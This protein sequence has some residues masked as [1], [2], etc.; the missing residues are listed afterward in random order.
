MRIFLCI[1]CSIFFACDWIHRYLFLF[2][3]CLLQCLN[4]FATFGAFLRRSISLSPSI[5][6]SPYITSVLRC[7]DLLYS[8]SFL[9]DVS[10]LRPIALSGVSRPYPVLRSVSGVRILPGCPSRLPL[11][12]SLKRRRHLQLTA[13]AVGWGGGGGGRRLERRPVAAVPPGAAVP[14]FSILYRLCRPV[15]RL[16]AVAACVEP[17][18][19][20]TPVVS[21]SSL[22]LI[23][24]LLNRNVKTD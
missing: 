5:S 3:I 7:L 2:E 12:S 9:P 22:R 24:P 10:F 15:W 19:K 16:Q 4:S 8:I 14:L 23:P 6:P 17:V 18:L 1:F 20:V 13:V 21:L 11:S